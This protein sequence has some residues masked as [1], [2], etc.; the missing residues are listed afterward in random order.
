MPSL[1]PGYAHQP[2][3]RVRRNDRARGPKRK[4]RRAAITRVL[5]AVQERELRVSTLQAR[6]ISGHLEAATERVDRHDVAGAVGTA[7][8]RSVDDQVYV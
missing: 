8:V 1:V 2:T 6:G 3:K 4:D 7:R 5:T